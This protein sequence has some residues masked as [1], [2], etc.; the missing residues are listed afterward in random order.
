MRVSAIRV[1]ALMIVLGWA[2]ADS[3]AQSWRVESLG[4]PVRAVTYGNSKA[5]L[6]PGPGGTGSMFY[7]SYYC[8]T[9]A[10]LVGYDFRSGKSV[11]RK[12]AS[13]GGY[14]VTLGRDGAIYV[15]GVDPGDLYRY[16]PR[17]DS[18][19]TLKASRFGVSYI[20][21]AA[22]AENGIIYCAAG[23]PHTN[24]VAYDPKA[25]SLKN[26]GEIAPGLNYMRSVCVDPLGKVWCGIGMN[27]HLVVYD[28]A[29]G[30]KREVLPPEYASN[31]NVYELET[32]GNRVL[33]SVLYDGTVLVYDPVTLQVTRKIPRPEGQRSWMIPPGG[34]DDAAYLYTIPA[35][36]V[37]RCDLKTG[38]LKLLV[39]DLGEVHAVESDRWL[40]A[41]YD[42]SYIVYDL[43]TRKVVST[44]RLTEGG[45]GM[46]VF[47]L[48]AGPD[49]NIYGSTYINMHLFRCDAAT[50]KLAD[51]GK[52]SRWPGQIDSMSLGHDGRIYLGAYIDAVVSI[53]DPRQPWR[54]GRAAD[55]N[56][57]EIG[58]VGKGQ[59]RT[60]ANCLG[61][62]G[63]IYVGSIPSYNTAKEGAFTICDP[64]TG[65]LDVRQ[66]F[67]KGGA[68]SALVADRR[69]VYG[70]GGGEF[71]VYDPKA[72]E[73]RFRAEL[74]VVSL[75]ILRED[76]SGGG[77][78]IGSGGGELFVYYPDF[79]KITSRTPNPA[80]DFTHMAAG[81]DGR[82]YGVNTKHVARI[83]EDGTSVAV[84][85]NE[86]GR[87]AAVDNE[88]R[89]Y[90]ARGPQLYRC[91]QAATS[92]P[93]Q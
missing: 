36:D 28:P 7:T 77:E 11:R 93:S 50:G 9:G 37:C 76:A 27:A 49:G 91:I 31:S 20:W 14:A 22:A 15:G 68:V 43:E 8:S 19:K 38:K 90:F 51:L 23:F 56:P 71:F 66:A 79:Y 87:F 72:D 4:L 35:Y 40:H 58:P 29:D 62:D 70:A 32:I 54:P 33:A 61:P 48:T 84:L 86:G 75:A 13:H 39:K 88:G 24:L 41:I 53:F 57:R 74:P 25:D 17:D 46:D 42:Q 5:V 44:Y 26:L 30:S 3:S 64:K 12:L 34:H 73:K 59:Y 45:D 67:V 85:T 89:L 18:L 52:A 82:I 65:A 60:Q 6:A 1:L 16:D 92:K 80:G 78:V 10:E 47:S 55:S 69:F 2:V 83:G 63:R 21:E 81:P